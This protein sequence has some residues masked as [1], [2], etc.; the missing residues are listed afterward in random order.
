MLSNSRRFVPID[1]QALQLRGLS[2]KATIQGAA[3]SYPCLDSWNF[4]KITI[5]QLSDG[6]TS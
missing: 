4:L 3:L 2:I 6:V 5:E 1:W